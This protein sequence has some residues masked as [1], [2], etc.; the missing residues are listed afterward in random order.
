MSNKILLDIGWKLLFKKLDVSLSDLL[1]RAKLPEGLFTKERPELTADQYCQLWIGMGSLL[2]KSSGKSWPL[3][4]VR[5]MQP[6]TFS[7]PL[8]AALCSPDLGTAL[9]RLSKFKRLC[10]PMDLVCKHTD[11]GMLASIVVSENDKSLPDSLVATELVF[12]VSL[13]RRATQEN[14]SPLA[15]N[16]VGPLGDDYTKFF[17]VT[18]EYGNTNSVHFS[19]ADIATPFLTA[20]AAM[21]GFF[22]PELRQRLSDLGTDD[23]LSKQVKSSLLELLPTGISSV[24]AVADKLAISKRTLQR[25][26]QLE[27]TNYQA[28][29]QSVR[30]ELAKHYLENS[31][32]SGIELSMLLGFE[33]YNSFLKA[34]NQWTGTS[35]EEHRKSHRQLKEHHERK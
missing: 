35:P 10:G 5:Q 8:F 23:S 4:F 25:K 15:V 18:P 22:E 2:E 28:V 27:G 34:F 1:K 9:Q 32:V 31:A 14:I 20:S 16:S 7:P 24:N 30:T 29:L 17:G 19:A 13:A 33:S 3:H 12:L 26:L 21:W 6:D 11:Q